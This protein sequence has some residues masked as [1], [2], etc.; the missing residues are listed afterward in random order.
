M[1][2]HLVLQ[3]VSGCDLD[4]TNDKAAQKMELQRLKSK[5]LFNSAR[6][7][8]S[9]AAFTFLPALLALGYVY[10]AN[11]ATNKIFL[12]LISCIVGVI[13]HKLS[14]GLLRKICSSPNLSTE[15]KSIAVTSFFIISLL[16]TALFL[17]AMYLVLFRP[18][19]LNTLAAMAYYNR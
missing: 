2:Y 13:G 17:L 7:G 12:L 4:L 1:R 15:V 19:F 8:L 14:S 6:A 18:E 10:R 11:P 9:Q 5:A 3:N 16:F